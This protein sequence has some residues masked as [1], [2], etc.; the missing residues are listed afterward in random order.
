MIE[1]DLPREARRLVTKWGK[2]YQKDL[3]EM[4]KT[5]NFRELPWQE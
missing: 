4:W 2:K 3:L 1:G 5:Q